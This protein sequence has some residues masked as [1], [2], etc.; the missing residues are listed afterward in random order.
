MSSITLSNKQVALMC[1]AIFG[2]PLVSFISCTALEK[3]LM[4][5]DTACM[6]IMGIFAALC[7]GNAVYA[8]AKA[9]AHVHRGQFIVIAATAAIAAGWGVF[10]ILRALDIIGVMNIN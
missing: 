10:L 8:V 3:V 4:R 7:L 6:L 9:K 5:N 1:A 2:W